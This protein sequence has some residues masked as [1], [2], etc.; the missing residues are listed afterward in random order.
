MNL[1]GGT[2]H[3]PANCFKMNKKS[4]MKIQEMA[5]VLM[6]IMIFFGIVAIFYIKI[7][8]S[9]LRGDVEMQRGEEANELVRRISGTPEFSFT[10]GECDSCIDMD[11]VLILKERKS[12]QGFWN[13]DYLKIETI[14]PLKNGECTRANYPNCN[15]ITLVNKTGDFGIPKS[16]FVA[17]CRQEFKGSENYVKC[18]LGRI[19][20]SG[21]SIGVEK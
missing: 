13:L 10:A 6:A 3:Y 20:A 21:K 5:F 2:M 8:L 16:A 1:E 15:S 19:S 14:Y 7:S 12:Y 11:K 17:L 18:E 4:Q 9:N